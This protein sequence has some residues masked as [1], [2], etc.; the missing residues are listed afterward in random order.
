MGKIKIIII[1]VIIFVGLAILCFMPL[2]RNIDVVLE[3]KEY[4]IGDSE[5][6]RDRVVAIQGKYKNYLFKENEF[7]GSSRRWSSHDGLFIVAPATNRELGLSLAKKFSEKSN[8]L[9]RVEWY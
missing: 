1:T 3:G 7:E 8:W 9:S 2:T 6:E 5:Y 4:R